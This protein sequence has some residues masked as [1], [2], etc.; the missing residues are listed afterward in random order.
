MKNLLINLLLVG[1]ALAGFNNSESGMRDDF[2]SKA[3]ALLSGRDGEAARAEMT[4]SPGCVEGDMELTPEQK[5][6]YYAM[7]EATAENRDEV[8]LMALEA[9]AQWPNKHLVYRFD[10]SLDNGIK[11]VFLEAIEIYEQ[12]TVVTFEEAL[13]DYSGTTVPMVVYGLNKGCT[14]TIGYVGPRGKMKLQTGTCN[15]LG[16]ILHEIGHAL[17]RIH[18][19]NRSDRDDFIRIIEPNILPGF[20]HNFMKVD[21]PLLAPYD[22]QS[23]MHYGPS[24]FSRSQ[25]SSTIIPHIEKDSYKMGKQDKMSRLDVF[26]VNAIYGVDAAC[27]DDLW[28]KC[29]RGGVPNKHCTCDCLPEFEGPYCELV[30]TQQTE[31]SGHYQLEESG[32]ISSPGYPENYPS[33][34]KCSYII[35]CSRNEV[36]QLDFSLF[37][38]EGYDCFYDKMDMMTGD[39]ITETYADEYCG[40]SLHGQRLLTKSN[41]ALMKFESDDM[42]NYEGYQ[43]SYL[44]IPPPDVVSK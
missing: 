18:E 6:V 1:H 5:D 9:F 3:V 41:V 19:H 14:S 31:C 11:P 26:T 21:Q 16:V 29:Q 7:R 15:S 13:D 23:I 20:E 17:G 44:C 43:I 33:N 28:D 22:L 34:A 10:A 40:D 27:P 4:P 37:S 25:W 38:I 2:S 12:H 36:V 30:V 35:E 32:L 24:A 39:L 8:R 42:Y